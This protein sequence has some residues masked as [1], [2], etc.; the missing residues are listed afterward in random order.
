[1]QAC[2][3]QFGRDG[4]AVVQDGDD[5]IVCRIHRA[6]CISCFFDLLEVGA[7]V[8]QTQ[9]SHTRAHP[10]KWATLFRNGLPLHCQHTVDEVRYHL[11]PAW[12]LGFRIDPCGDATDP[13]DNPSFRTFC[14][15]PPPTTTT[16]NTNLKNF[17]F[18]FA[19]FGLALSPPRCP[20]HHHRRQQTT[21]NVM[22]KVLP[23]KDTNCTACGN[24]TRGSASRN[25]INT[26]NMPQI[27]LSFVGV[28]TEI[29][30]IIGCRSGRLSLHAA[31]IACK[32]RSKKT[33]TKNKKKHTWKYVL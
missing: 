3:K 26:L 33:K 27:S 10:L 6:T 5:G 23:R 14:R 12:P 31:T 4:R 32:T 21:S 13:T 20:H 17:K 29:H 19:T 9:F 2:R 22:S 25:C 16:H 28:L 8:E 7:V 30:I 11:Q 1:M 18:E 24:C 15:D